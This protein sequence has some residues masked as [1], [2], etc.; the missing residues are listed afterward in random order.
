MRWSTS[1]RSWNSAN[2]EGD[3]AEPLAGESAIGD[4]QLDRQRRGLR[5]GSL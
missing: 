1:R 2:Q 3:L 4:D 5:A